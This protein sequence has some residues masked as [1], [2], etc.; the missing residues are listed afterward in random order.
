[1]SFLNKK[2]NKDSLIDI[3]TL[4]VKEFR[5]LAHSVNAMIHQRVVAEGLRK[6]ES[7]KA[8][9]YLNV[10]EVIILAL[11]TKGNVTLINKKGCETLGYDEVYIIGKNWFS[12]FIPPEDKHRLSTKFSKV[13]SGKNKV[14][15]QNGQNYIITGTGE[16]R[17]ISWLNTLL[18]DENNVIL[19]Q[20]QFRS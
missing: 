9:T 20:S 7:D 1:M 19:R 4:H 14:K 12:N 10:A 8:R 18:Y 3:N 2:S 16:R 5:E 15:F 11:D 17:I 6:K 13:I